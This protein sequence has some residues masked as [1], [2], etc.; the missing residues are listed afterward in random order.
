MGLDMYLNAK[1]FLSSFNEFDVAAKDAIKELE[2]H[3]TKGL[4]PNEISF[5]AMY[6]R[7]ANHIH[8]WFVENVQDGED[9]CKPHGVSTEQLK[10]LVDV[11]K[12]VLEN[13]KL[14]S[15]LLPVQAGFFFGGQEYDEWY[16]GDVEETVKGLEK[17]LSIEGVGMIE[18]EYQ[19]SW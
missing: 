18:F 17:I 12:Q 9:E 4:E 19:S 6:W 7:K 13:R 11:C 3:G 8:R 2:L 1:R 15:K 16:F 5:Q 10:E 14:A